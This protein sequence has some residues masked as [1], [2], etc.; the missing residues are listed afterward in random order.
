VGQNPSLRGS[1][2]DPE[3]FT[4]TSELVPGQGGRSFKTSRV[5]TPVR[6]FAGDGRFQ[7]SSITENAEGLDNFAKSENSP[8]SAEKN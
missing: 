7:S 3:Q 5:F 2:Q 6:D 1:L 4:R 8:T